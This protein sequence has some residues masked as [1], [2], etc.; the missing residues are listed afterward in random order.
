MQ[1]HGYSRRIAQSTGKKSFEKVRLHLDVIK[2]LGV[3]H[4]LHQEGQ[5]VSFQ[6]HRKSY[7]AGS[8]A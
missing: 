8:F 2:G 5:Q 6:D 4:R 3:V 1:V 7:Y